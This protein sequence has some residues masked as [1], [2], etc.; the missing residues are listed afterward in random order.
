MADNKSNMN[1]SEQTVEE[2]IVVK[3][4]VKKVKT[5]KTSWIQQLFFGAGLIILGL[6]L[7]SYKTHLIKVIGIVLGV[8]ILLQTIEDIRSLSY[9]EYSVLGKN[10]FISKVIKIVI[11][12]IVGLLAIL[13]PLVMYSFFETIVIWVLGAY[14]IVDGI[15][16]LSKAIIFRGT[17]LALKAFIVSVLLMVLGAVLLFKGDS[18]ADTIANIMGVALIATGIVLIIMGAIAKNKVDNAVN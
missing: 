15:Y 18:I 3:G 6:L 8:M 7:V 14:M 4:E 16:T 1:N 13:S 11:S 17:P 2:V 10:F 5:L 12:C 9:D